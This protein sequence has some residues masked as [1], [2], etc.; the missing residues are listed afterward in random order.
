MV[1]RASAV[2]VRLGAPGAQRSGAWRAM[3]APTFDV[4]PGGSDCHTH[5]L[6]DGRGMADQASTDHLYRRAN[7]HS[8]R[9]AM[10]H[11]RAIAFLLAVLV[12]LSALGAEDPPKSDPPKSTPA[13]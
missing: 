4:P 11:I 10:S 7:R 2:S 6:G 1:P 5:V 13:H 3:T 9:P 12:P 8:Y